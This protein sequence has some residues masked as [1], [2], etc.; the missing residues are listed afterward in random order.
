MFFTIFDLVLIL[1][2]M[3]FITFGFVMGF[4]EAIGAV[5]G[6]VVGTW[7]GGLFYTDIGVWLQPYLVNENLAKVVAFIAIFIV[8]SRLTGFLFHLVSKS[9]RLIKIIPFTKTIDRVV[10]A[11][12]GTI[13]GVL[14]LGLILLT[15]SQ[16][17]FSDWWDNLLL[18]SKVAL[19]LIALAR[20]LT[21]I[22][23][24]IFV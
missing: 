11:G 8:V 4:I 16:F 21:P 22:L 5:I 23:P 24:K 19:Y 10:G 13:E 3:I 2:L 17:P 20:L 1:V 9:F 15:I 12:L 18:E 14:V 6:L 7:I